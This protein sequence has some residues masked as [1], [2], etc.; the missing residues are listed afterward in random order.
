MT[1]CHIDA[2]AF[3]GE[4]VSRLDG[5][6]L[7]TPF[8]LP[9]EDVEVMIYEK[10]K[11]FGRAHLL[12]IS[13]ESPNRIT[14]PC[15]YF[16]KCGGCQ[17]Q[18][19]SYAY[20]LSLKRQFL[21]DSFDRI[22]KIKLL[23]PEVIGSSKEKTYR[24]HITCKLSFLEQKWQLCFSAI[25][26]TLLP[27]QECLLLQEPE[28]AILSSLQKAFAQLPPS[29]P[30]HG[31]LKLMKTTDGYLGALF[32]EES[33]TEKNEQT[34]F[35]LLSSYFES[36][37]IQTPYK[38]TKTGTL[39]HSFICLGLTIYYSPFSF[40]Q[41]H[42]EQSERIYSLLANLFQENTTILDLYCGIGISSLILAKAGK[43]VLGIEINQESLALA[44]KNAA[45][46]D[47]L[48]EF[49]CTSAENYF[50]E[51]PSL[52]QPDGLLINPPKSGLSQEVQQILASLPIKTIVYISC[53]P[54]TLAR[55]SAFLQTRGYSI[56]FIQGYDMFPQTTHVE[57]VVQFS[58]S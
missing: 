3:G 1:R 2:V 32:V 58:K 16:T 55:D 12:F 37:Y 19:A 23:I 44:K 9:T 52:F 30:L 48:V 36:F 43:H 51:A 13:Q 46:N 41:N 40:L 25:D 33:L 8:T 38:T 29:I 7:F 17:L 15:P 20:Q 6:V 21:Q 56:T 31:R 24:R 4:G 14:P 50:Q 47:C 18:H 49:I 26:H 34:L 42:P 57:T 22:G 11:R 45:C 35:L 10:K 27:I 28:D 53:Y 39:Q 54:P 5:L